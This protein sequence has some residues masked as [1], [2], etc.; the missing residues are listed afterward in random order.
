MV[1]QLVHGVDKNLPVLDIRTQ[2]EVVDRLLFNERL[3]ARLLRS[4]RWHR[5]GTG[6]HWDL[7]AAVV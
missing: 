7:R 1:R 3:V 5:A 2:S 4:L 6:L